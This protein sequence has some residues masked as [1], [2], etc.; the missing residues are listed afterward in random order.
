[1]EINRQWQNDTG[2]AKIKKRKD[3]EC[4]HSKWR[5]GNEK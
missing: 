2:P 4:G 3:E 5:V 1:M